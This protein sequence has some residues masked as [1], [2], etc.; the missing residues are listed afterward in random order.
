MEAL[1]KTPVHRLPPDELAVEKQAIKRRL[2]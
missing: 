2:R 1:Y